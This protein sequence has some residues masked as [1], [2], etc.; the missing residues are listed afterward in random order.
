MA[1]NQ[2]TDPFAVLLDIEKRT[3]VNAAPLPSL[4]EVRRL[5]TGVGFL[6]NTQRYVVP[7]NE[8]AEILHIPEVKKVPGVKN[9]FRGI[10]NVRGT[11]L[12]VTDLSQFLGG[13]PIKTNKRSRVL[14]MNHD[15]VYSG[16]IVEEVLGL[17]HFEHEQRVK[18]LEVEKNVQSYVKGGFSRDGENWTVFSLYE[19][20]KDA[21][22]IQVAV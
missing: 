10:S 21:M 17:Q 20:A 18:E 5:W 16:V 14:V 1:A 22:F 2:S 3:R 8:V 12:P 15:G 4:D 7:L 13:E 19:L 11:L 9:W 6:L